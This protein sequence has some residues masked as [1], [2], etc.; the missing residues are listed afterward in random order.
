MSFV[1]MV[2]I[3]HL[4][5]STYTWYIICT[6]FICN[7]HFASMDVACF[8]LCIHVDHERWPSNLRLDEGLDSCVCLTFVVVVIH[9]GLRTKDS[10]GDK[11]VTLRPRIIIWLMSRSLLNIRFPVLS[12]RQ[13]PHRS[14]QYPSPAQTALLS[15]CQR[16]QGLL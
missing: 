16:P 9:I 5:T 6:E 7:T 13:T 10:A 4:C 1:N 14:V 3:S 8:C 15:T 12:I 2:F 11:S